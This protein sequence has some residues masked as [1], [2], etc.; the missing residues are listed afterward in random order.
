[1]TDCKQELKMTTTSALRLVNSRVE[2][3][4]WNFKLKLF[5]IPVDAV[6]LRFLKCL[7]DWRA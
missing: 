5:F 1:M 6:R 2:F 7:I 4:V 3:H